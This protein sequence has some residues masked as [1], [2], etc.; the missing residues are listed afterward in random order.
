MTKKRVSLHNGKRSQ[1][2]G[3]IIKP[4]HNDTDRRKNENVKAEWVERNNYYNCYDGEYSLETQDGKMSFEESELRYYNEHFAAALKAQNEKHIS[5]RQR[6]RVKKM[7]DW[8][9]SP[10]YAPSESIL[11]VGNVDD[12]FADAKTLKSITDEYIKLLRDWSAAHNNCLFVLN[13]A[14]HADEYYTD[15]DTGKDK[16]SSPHVHLR[17]VWQYVDDNGNLAV[18]EEKALEQAGVELPDP[19]KKPGRYN[20]RVMTF[21]AEFRKELQK[22]VKE[23]GYDIEIEPLPTKRKAKDRETFVAEKRAEKEIEKALEMQQKAQEDSK[24]ATRMQLEAIRMQREANEQKIKNEADAEYNE[25][26][27][28]KNEDKE[29]GLIEIKEKLEAEKADF[30][31][32]R[33]YL[34][35][36]ITEV[37]GMRGRLIKGIEENDR[38]TTLIND[39]RAKEKLTNR[40]NINKN[41]FSDPELDKMVESIKRKMSDFEKR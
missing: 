7:E 8:L 11:R 34:E 15:E 6:S 1:K 21:T 12:G 2:T 20:N 9:A 24:L 40:N 31:S 5:A 32:R 18:G 38:L 25:K 33:E 14:L 26:V 35:E 4:P 3:R 23:H 16:M 36:M 17:Y 22:I 10:R 28:R 39:I 30:E 41:R 13:Y 27:R 19:S 29:A 37:T